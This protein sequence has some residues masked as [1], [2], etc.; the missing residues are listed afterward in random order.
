M[1]E[2]GEPGAPSGG[3][4]AGGWRCRGGRRGAGASVVLYIP[5]APMLGWWTRLGSESDDVAASANLVRTTTSHDKCDG[6]HHRGIPS[7][8]KLWTCSPLRLRAQGSQ[9]RQG[10]GRT[11]NGMIGS[12]VWM[13]LVATNH[14]HAA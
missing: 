5:L 12:V 14:G 10:C 9:L 6:R 4:L 11:P 13:V 8:G 2:V 3:Q 1:A 7:G